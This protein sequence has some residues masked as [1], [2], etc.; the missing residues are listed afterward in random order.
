MI[1]RLLSER[2]SQLGQGSCSDRLEPVKDPV[3]ANFRKIDVYT[4]SNFLQRKLYSNDMD[5]IVC[6]NQGR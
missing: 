1:S 4:R 3:L 6:E 5:T 2:L